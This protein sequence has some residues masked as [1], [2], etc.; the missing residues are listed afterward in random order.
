MK[1]ALIT[2]GLFGAFGYWL[3]E[4]SLHTWGELPVVGGG[5]GCL[6]VAALVP[7]RPWLKAFGGVASLALYA[8]AF[9]IGSL[10]FSRAFNECVERGEEVRVQLTEYRNRHN[11]Y[12][13]HLGQLEGFALCERITRP[14]ILDY[15]K[16]KDGYELS[17]GDWLVEHKATE[18]GPFMGHK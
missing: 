12:P 3:G 8:V 10:S 16:T 5:I 6:V 9:Y 4:G 11:Q 2:A 1:V 17:F 14:T 18:S 15:K 13:G 7:G